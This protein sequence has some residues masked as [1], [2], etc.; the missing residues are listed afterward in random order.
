MLLPSSLR[1]TDSYSYL[2]EGTELRCLKTIRRQPRD[3][4]GAPPVRPIQSPSLSSESSGERC[5]LYVLE[6]D[7]LLQYSFNPSC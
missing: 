3:G 6:T 2:K 7:R 1:E 4:T 5:D